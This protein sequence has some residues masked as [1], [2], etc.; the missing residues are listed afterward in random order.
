MFFF[1]FQHDHDQVPFLRILA[2]ALAI[3]DDILIVALR[4]IFCFIAN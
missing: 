4:N 2:A 1:K 3:I